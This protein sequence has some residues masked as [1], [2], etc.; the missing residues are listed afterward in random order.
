M[1]MTME[2]KKVLEAAEV[3]FDKKYTLERIY[4]KVDEGVEVKYVIKEDGKKFAIVNM[5]GPYNR[6]EQLVDIMNNYSI[7]VF[8][9]A[10]NRN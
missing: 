7:K 5:V 6:F 4:S 10:I 3:V 1:E 8:K 2:L 9:N